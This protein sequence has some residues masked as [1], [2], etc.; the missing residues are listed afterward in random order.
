V[1][2]SLTSRRVPY[3]GT[4][5]VRLPH[6]LL[7]RL[8]PAAVLMLGLATGGCSFSYQLGSL[9]GPDDGPAQTASV[10]PAGATKPTSAPADGDLVFARAAAAELLA[11]GTPH[12]SVPWE[13]PHTGARG[14]VT[15]VASA[16]PQDGLECRDFL[17][18]YVR[19]G[20]EAWLE[21]EACHV[22]RGKWEVRALRPLK[23]S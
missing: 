7:P 20:A 11:R 5:A 4:P 15:A 9:F 23:R 19:G 1:T 21:G 18:S 2:G 12:A 22:H 13:N 10:A 16:Y 14:T 6:R 3:K 8:A 17:A